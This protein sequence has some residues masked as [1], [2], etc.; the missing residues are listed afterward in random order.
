MMFAKRKRSL[1]EELRVFALS[2]RIVVAKL[3]WVA[4]IGACLL[5]ISIGLFKLLLPALKN[6]QASLA[7]EVTAKKKQVST[8]AA[9]KPVVDPLQNALNQLKEKLSASL[10][11][12]V[13]EQI[14]SEAIASQLQV[15]AVT[16]QASSNQSIHFHAV[17]MSLNL[18]GSY[19][20]LRQFLDAV[21]LNLPNVVLEGISMKRESIEND[22][23]DISLRFQLFLYRAVGVENTTSPDDE[24]KNTLQTQGNVEKESR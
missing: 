19:A 20:G 3:G 12:M 7:N 23:L 10:P 16:Y 6:A 21:S 2:T 9:I 22:Q 1:Q 24:G 18:R 17:Q 4:C 11:E 15:G 14:Y 13:A 5:V 8:S